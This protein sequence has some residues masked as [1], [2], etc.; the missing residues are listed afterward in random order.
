MTATVSAMRLKSEA[1]EALVAR[2]WYETVLAL[3]GEPVGQ[4]ELEDP[5]RLEAGLWTVL[6]HST[7]MDPVNF[8]WPTTVDLVA[9]LTLG[10]VR[11]GSEVVRL[12][13]PQFIPGFGPELA[14]SVE[15]GQELEEPEVLGG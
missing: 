15:G 8:S 1:A 10:H 13:P 14:V 3:W 2:E 9:L 4:F 11:K 5:W 7:L 12:G 6:R